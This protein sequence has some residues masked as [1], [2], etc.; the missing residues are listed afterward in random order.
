M[1]LEGSGD[2]AALRVCVTHWNHHHH[3]KTSFTPFNPNPTALHPCS[4]SSASHTLHVSREAEMMS[5]C[6][7]ELLHVKWEE[8]VRMKE[9]LMNKD[10][11]RLVWLY[12]DHSTPFTFHFLTSFFLHDWGRLFLSKSN[13]FCSRSSPDQCLCAH[14]LHSN[15]IISAS[16]SSIRRHQSHLAFK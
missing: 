3:H 5:A 14:L 8:R 11:R 4:C 7:S 13:I 10:W 12:A 1:T 9:T 6:V 2:M 15:L 16:N